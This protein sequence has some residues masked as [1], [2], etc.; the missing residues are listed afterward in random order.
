MNLKMKTFFFAAAFSLFFNAIPVHADPVSVVDAQLVDLGQQQFVLRVRSSGPQAFD[1]IPP[2]DPA[3]LEVRLYQAKLDNF[4]PISESDFGSISFIQ[5]EDDQVL[6]RFHLSDPAFRLHVN[7]GD[8]ANT[9]EIT[10]AWSPDTKAP[11][12]SD[13]KVINVSTT[14][15][16][17]QWVTDEAADAQVAFGTAQP[18]SQLT[19]LDAEMKV[20]HQVTLTGLQPKTSYYFVVKS[21]DAAGNL[22]SSTSSIF[23]TNAPAFQESGGQV[24]I[25]TENSDTKIARNAKEWQ[26]R[27]N[28]TG[29]SGSGFMTAQPN[30]GAAINSG[31]AATSPELIYSIN[32]TKA[33]VY[34]VWLRGRGAN[35]NDDSV[36]A[37]LDGIALGSADKIDGFT[38]SWKWSRNTM[39][40]VPA[41]VNV[42]APGIHTFHL[43]MREDG[44][45]IDKILL[46]SNNT[47]AA[48]AGSGPAES[49]KSA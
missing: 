6:I 45:E 23:K 5:E 1:I 20:N 47:S 31:Y 10:M 29:F 36:H 16:M 28:A 34:Y 32:F 17:I 8:N 41:A 13:I 38:T 9:I 46:T 25:E 42:P 7:Q 27:S 44:M 49:P 33:G 3:I 18:E 14:G 43:W 37:G 24:V 21:K 26:L 11:T 4:A 15:T 35:G 39:D 30:T 22:A 12:L 48:P 40:G 19:P 2:H